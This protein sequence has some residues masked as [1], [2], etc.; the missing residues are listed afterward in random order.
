V[1]HGRIA[2]RT[3]IGRN[4]RAE[5]ARTYIWDPR[6]VLEDIDG[7]ARNTSL[8]VGDLQRQPLTRGSAEA[9]TS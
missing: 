6:G 8:A 2:S 9:T 5:T 3:S 1:D 7:Q 4:R